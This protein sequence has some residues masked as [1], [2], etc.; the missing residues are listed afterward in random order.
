MEN[1]IVQTCA[2]L[3]EWVIAS[4][5]QFIVIKVIDINDRSINLMNIITTIKLIDISINYYS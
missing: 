5:I 2:K 3:V 4:K 1:L